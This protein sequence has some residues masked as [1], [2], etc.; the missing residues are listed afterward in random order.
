MVLPDQVTVKGQN[1]QGFVIQGVQIGSHEAEQGRPAGLLEGHGFFQDPGRVR[2]RLHHGRH[3]V[4][5]FGPELGPI[6]AVSL[7]TV[8]LFGVMAG[9]QHDAAHTIE[10]TKRE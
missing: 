3:L 2:N 9:C 5:F 8:V 10:K 6:P 1:Q 7:K 4:G